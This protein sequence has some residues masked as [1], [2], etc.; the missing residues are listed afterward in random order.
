MPTMTNGE[1]FRYDFGIYAT[2]LW[3]MPEDN[4]LEWL[5]APCDRERP[6]NMPSAQQEPLTDEEQRI[7]LAAM[8]REEKV[9][10]GVDRNHD[11]DRL[12]RV[13]KEIRRKVKG[14]LWT[15]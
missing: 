9:C 8:G 5:N 14:A 10:A 6:K 15:I 3:A 13:C 2:E 11:E 1:A 4:F 12:V 7:F